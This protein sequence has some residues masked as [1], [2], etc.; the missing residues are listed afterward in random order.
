[1]LV[2]LSDL[3]LT[4]GTSCETLDPGA[5]R[6]FCE[7]LQDLA[8]RASW[9][10]D[11]TYNPIP[12]IDI[13]LLGD[14][15]D[16]MRSSRWLMDG[17]KPWNS[18]SSREFA[19]RVNSIVSGILSRNVETA[20]ILRGLS[21]RQTIRIPA[22]AKNG[23][24]AFENDLQPVPVRLH[25]MVGDADW[26]L[27]V[28]GPEMNHVRSAIVDTLGLANSASEPFPHEP[29][30]DVSLNLM[31]R[32]HRVFARHGDV[33][34]NLSFSGH[35][36]RT[37][38]NDLLLVE[39]LMPFRFELQ[40]GL[41]DQL[42]ASAQLGIQELDH[43]RPLVM[44][45]LCLRQMM[46]VS[47]P[48]TSLQFE[49]KNC[50]DRA[51]DKLMPLVHQVDR[52]QSLGVRNLDALESLL[53]FREQEDDNWGTRIMDW[54][55]LQSG[56]K[57]SSLSKFAMDEA[58]FRNRRAKHI[59]FGHTHA[60]ET[61]PLDASFADGYVLSQLYF[62]SGTWRRVYMPTRGNEGWREFLPAEKMT[63]L[64]F[65]RDD[66][67]QGAPYEVWNG[68]LGTAPSPIRR[69]RID[70]AQEIA[71]PMGRPILRPEPRP[72][73]KSS[74]SLGHSI[75]APPHTIQE[76]MAGPA[77]NSVDSVRQ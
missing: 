44:A 16:I 43:V 45:P 60:D 2:I 24:P 46:R 54:L 50:W 27:H 35:R 10:S 65:Y 73:S 69:I 52:Y 39:G 42:P 74:S 67:R 28:T 47:C 34:D 68:I 26:P 77:R 63:Y 40:H 6:I 3:H 25:Y 29:R 7:R 59:V 31:L 64:T 56:G 37:S 18:Q 9:R 75:P 11:G 57:S 61:V 48:V 62:N 4:D 21:Q 76:K 32:Q 1:M 70:G 36:D 8:V 66:E 20:S 49:I 58:D 23:K 72:V 33:F 51:V 71:A 30:E 41:E 55:R 38:L 22:G 5:F 15:F 13:L 12:G 19:E 14:V 53:K 17:A